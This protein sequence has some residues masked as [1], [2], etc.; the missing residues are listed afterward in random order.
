MCVFVF[1]LLIV[2]RKILYS[3]KKTPERN[4]RSSQLIG[5]YHTDSTS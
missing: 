1:D 3:R 4:Y 2:A 5:G